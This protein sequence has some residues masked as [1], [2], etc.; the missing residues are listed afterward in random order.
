MTAPVLA[1]LLGPVLD[2]LAL[3]YAD[4]PAEVA[5]L[6]RAHAA[7]VTRLDFSAVA[8]DATDLDR[9]LSAAEA[10]GT[11][12][13]LAELSPAAATALNLPDF[14]AMLRRLTATTEDPR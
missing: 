2:E 4:R 11:R 9:M 12:N 7:R 3:A 14:D 10:D 8:D 5:A 6:L 1:D 13:A